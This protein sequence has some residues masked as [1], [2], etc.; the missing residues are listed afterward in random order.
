MYASSLAARGLD[1][2]RGF[3][4]FAPEPFGNLPAA[5]LESLGRREVEAG[6]RVGQSL[7]S[8]LI[9]DHDL[10]HQRHDAGL[11]QN[12]T[13]HPA[14]EMRGLDRESVT[15]LQRV[16][17]T[18]LSPRHATCGHTLTCTSHTATGTQFTLNHAVSLTF[19]C[20]AAPPESFAC[21]IPVPVDRRRL[22]LG[23]GFSPSSSS[24][25]C[26]RS[27]RSILELLRVRRLSPP[28]PPWSLRGITMD[29]M[30]TVV[31]NTPMSRRDKQRSESQVYT[32][33][34]VASCTVH[35][36]YQF[37]YHGAVLCRASRH[38]AGSSRLPRRPIQ[39][40]TP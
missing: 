11:V 3:D 30:R 20:D 32:H 31:C 29:W 23:D 34:P 27:R 2:T 1:A 8:R 18:S 7:P 19:F 10:L 37:T 14:A 17:E 24:L 33:W 15:H 16:V 28:I 5:L 13:H 36:T 25:R 35:I 21:E 12:R 40:H 38:G 26:L 9:L 22:L 39:S 6:L 4:A